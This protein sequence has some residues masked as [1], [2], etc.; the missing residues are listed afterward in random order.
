MDMGHLPP[1]MIRSGRIELWLE[2]RLPD[3]SARRAIFGSLV[4]GLP[5]KL[6]TVELDLLVSA[7]DGLTRADMKRVVD[8]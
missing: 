7:A 3:E 6:E 2:T 4:K 8:D 5:L 1:A